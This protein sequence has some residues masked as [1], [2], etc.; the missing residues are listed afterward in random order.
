MRVP[1]IDML[2]AALEAGVGVGILQCVVGD[3]NPR[4]RRIAPFGGETHLWLLTHPQLRG[5]ARI[6]TFMAFLRELI[7]RDRDLFEGRR[8]RVD[9]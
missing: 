6:M 8:P 7:A 2:V 3:T 4:L 1:R 9:C 5:A